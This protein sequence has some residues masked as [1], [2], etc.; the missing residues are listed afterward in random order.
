MIRLPSAFLTRPIAH[1]AL[2]DKADGRPENS[3]AAVMAAVEAGYGIEID[4]QLSK[5]RQAMVFHD[6]SLSRLTAASGPFA[7]HSAKELGDIALLGG[8]GEGIPTLPEVLDLVAGRVPLLIELKDQDGQM[9]A[10]IGA[11]EE[12]TAQALE[13]YKGDV[14]LMSFNPNS[15]RSLAKLCP[16]IACGITTSSYDPANWAPL[17]PKVCDHLRAIPDF[18]DSGASFISHEVADL[19]SPRVAELRA[20]GAGILCWTVKSPQQEAQARK[21]AANITFEG[22]LA[23]FPA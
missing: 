8:A 21:V 12:A 4:L 15:V 6:Y 17:S 7:Q 13:G 18:E 10:N 5:D 2:H 23:P 22:Y 16:N 9:G 3:K 1:R 20:K 14:A 19:G 11:L